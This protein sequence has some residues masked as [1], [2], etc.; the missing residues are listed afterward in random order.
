MTIG[1]SNGIADQLSLPSMSECLFY[2]PLRLDMPRSNRLEGVLGNR[3]VR[4]LIARSRGP[5]QLGKRIA[6]EDGALSARL[7]NPDCEIL[8]GLCSHHEMHVGKSG[9]AELC[10]DTW[11]RSGFVGLQ[12]ELGSHA[13]HRIDLTAK[14]GD[15][16][17]VHDTGGGEAKVNRDIRRDDQVID[18]RYAL[19]WVDEQPSPIQRDDLH[20]ERRFRGLQG[21]RGI[22][23]MRANPGNTSQEENEQRGYGPND[24]FNPSGIFPL[25]AI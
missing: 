24:Q 2:R 7:G 1:W 11:I 23:L 9:A 8:P 3:S 25:G 14:L 17:T 6:I 21:P 16:E 13:G 20:L 18:S 4:V 19:A 12:I 5:E 22:K 15:E 10:R